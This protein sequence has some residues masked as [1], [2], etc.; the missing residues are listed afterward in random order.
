MTQANTN[1][2]FGKYDTPH[3]TI[4]FDKIKTEH[5]EPAF[6]EGIRQR[7]AEIDRIASNPEPPTFEN[8][9]VALERSGALLDRVSSAFFNLLSAESNDEMMEIS[10]RVSPK[11]TESAND[12]LLNEPLFARIK[13][14]YEQKDRLGLGTEDAKLLQETYESFA[15]NGANLSTDDKEKFRRLTAEEARLTLTFD[16]NVLKDKNSFEMLLTDEARLDGLPASIREAAAL[17]AKEKGKTGWL[18]DLSAPSYVPFMQYASDRELRKKLYLAYQAVGNKNDQYDNKENIRQIVATRLAIANLLGYETYA[19]Y[20]LHRRMAKTP[21]NVYKLLNE[22]LEAYRPAA[23]DE[24]NRVQE[25]A[26]D[27]EKK[28]VTVMPWDWSYYSE[29]LKDLTFG[30]NDEMTRPYFELSQVQKS[31]FGL[32]TQLYGITFRENKTIPVYHPDVTPYEV[33]DAD[34]RFL[35]VLYTDFHPR[36]GKQSG[37]WMNDMKGQYKVN[38]TDSRPHIVIVMNFTKPTE[39]EPSLL[40][41][42]E[43][44]TFLHEFGHAIH[45]MLADGTYES[46]SG[47][48]VYRDFV[49]LPSQLMENWLT[50]KAFL[51]QIAVH[52]QTGEKIPDE[53]VRKLIDAANFNAGYLCLRQLSFGFLDMAWHTLTAPFEGDAARFE[54][55]AWSAAQV[56]PAVE[57]SLMSSSFSHI[58]AGG[59]AAGYYGY[60]WAEVLDADAFSLFKERG[61]FD[62]ETARSFRDNVLSKGGTEDPMTLYVRFRGQEPSVDALLRRNGIRK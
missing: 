60:K 11:L 42:N 6:D 54:K 4:P 50:E 19:D 33:F 51:D 26:T 20:A 15:E 41:F 17:R 10:Q 36:E 55:A 48:N 47:T 16:Q 62:R 1:P 28:A 39:T 56:L 9:I 38:G 35:A 27:Y 13:A 8:T 61:I 25:F 31:V 43:V 22:L 44:E 7:K 30:I 32:A 29:K 14:V 12:L 3:G 40:T 49:E 5:Y 2:F 57:G 21:A 23:L 53:M 18:F 52:Y 45:G 37:A 46:L 58:F 34:G 59:Y 24:Y